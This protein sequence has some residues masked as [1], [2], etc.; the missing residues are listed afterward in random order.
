LEA[1]ITVASHPLRHIAPPAKAR[2]TPCQTWVG[3]HHPQPS[4]ARTGPAQ[5]ESWGHTR[6]RMTAQS[7]FSL[8]TRNTEGHKTQHQK[9]S[10]ITGIPFT[11]SGINSQPL[12][13]H[14]KSTAFGTTTP[15]PGQ[16]TQKPPSDRSS[17]IPTCRAQRTFYHPTKGALLQQFRSRI[18]QHSSAKCAHLIYRTCTPPH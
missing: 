2:L 1:L 15:T 16:P 9:H 4:R 18:P 5:G 10:A 14:G 3:H 8:G 13:L 11:G 17:A 6:R 12:A 7:V